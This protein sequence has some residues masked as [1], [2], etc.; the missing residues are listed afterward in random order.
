MIGEDLMH[1]KVDHE[2]Q[3]DAGK[4]GE[5]YQRSSASMVIHFRDQVAGGDV[6][7]DAAGEREGICN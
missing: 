3:G 6:K 4:D 2:K 7:G 5:R 1:Q